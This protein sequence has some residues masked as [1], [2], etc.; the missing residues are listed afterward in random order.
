MEFRFQSQIIDCL[1]EGETWIQQQFKM[2]DKLNQ[3]HLHMLGHFH[4]LAL[5]IP[6]YWIL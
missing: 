2:K 3:S 1:N 6:A 4:C 5:Y